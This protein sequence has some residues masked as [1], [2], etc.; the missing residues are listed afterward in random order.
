[1]KI[2]RVEATYHNVPVKLPLDKSLQM[3]TVIARVETDEG[4]TGIGIARNRMLIPTREFINRQLAPFLVG[5]SPLET[6]KLWN[7]DAYTE[8][9]LANL[10]M[11]NSWMVRSGFSS[12]DIALW[13][14]KGKYFN[15]P[16]F[17]LLGGASNRIPAYVTFGLHI[18]SREE[19]IEAARHF[20]EMGQNNLKMQ[21]SYTPGL[22]MVEEEARVRVVRETMGDDGMLMVD[23]NDRLNFMQARQLAQRIEPYNITWFDAPILTGMDVTA[24]AALRKCTSIPIGHSGSLPARRWFYRELIV[25][26]S[27]DIV[28]PNVLHVGGYT[29]ALKIAHMAQAFNIPV[30]GGGGEPHHN[31]HLI[32]AV[33]NGWIVE[34]HYGHTLRNEAIFVDPPSFDQGW[35]TL[36]E[37]PGLGFELNEAACKEFQVP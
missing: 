32:A 21:V 8:L 19:L 1:M 16:V 13:D 26:E 36:P 2:T 27:V 37:K 6:E 23:A 25:N 7:K 29:E 12:I 3:G 24:L 15:Q 5:K 33:A 4:I 35:V 9:G 10:D 11:V 30:A 14:I 17:R 20:L 31:M 28:Q 22:D 18:Y 34:F